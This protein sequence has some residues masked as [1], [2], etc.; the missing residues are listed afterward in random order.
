MI[1]Y[2]RQSM[3][4]KMIII[5]VR[6]VIILDINKNELMHR[7]MLPKT[8]LLKRTANQIPSKSLE[9]FMTT[10]LTSSDHIFKKKLGK[11]YSRI[12]ESIS[13]HAKRYPESLTCSNSYYFENSLNN[14]LRKKYISES[15]EKKSLLEN[16][17]LMRF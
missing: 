5:K 11:N 6:P 13:S 16:S 4:K 14:F 9:Y 15:P 7:L 10:R 1:Y 17:P 12:Q 2:I 8:I 3:K